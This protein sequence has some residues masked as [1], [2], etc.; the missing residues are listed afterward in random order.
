MNIKNDFDFSYINEVVN[1]RETMFRKNSIV[2][3]N[4]KYAFKLLNTFPTSRLK[5]DV[6]S[7]VLFN[8]I[9]LTDWLLNRIVVLADYEF[10]EFDDTTSI[11]SLNGNHLYQKDKPINKERNRKL[12]RLHYVMKILSVLYTTSYVAIPDKD[13]QDQQFINAFY[14][15][16]IRLECDDI[17]DSVIDEIIKRESESSKTKIIYDKYLEYRLVDHFIQG[18]YNP[19]ISDLYDDMLKVIHYNQFSINTYTSKM[20][21]V[22]NNDYIRYKSLSDIRR[23]INRELGGTNARETFDKLMDNFLI[24]N[25]DDFIINDLLKCLVQDSE[26]CRNEQYAETLFDNFRDKYQ[27][28][29]KVYHGSRDVSGRNRNIDYLVSRYKDGSISSSKDIKQAL[30]FAA[31][32]SYDYMSKSPIL[33]KGFVAELDITEDMKAL[34]VHKMLIDL[35]EK[36]PKLSGWI[37]EGFLNEQEVLIPAEYIKAARI[38]S[39]EDAEKLLKEMEEK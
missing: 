10:D 7:L 18:V 38:M 8:E 4:K 35:K 33:H 34:D 19:I 23:K 11:P 36:L 32:E 6:S 24:E 14:N 26:E 17:L 28:I 37:S 20:Y 15:I 9:N 1:L 21:E 39:Y 12:F 25:Y 16:V 31:Y 22:Y 2:R 27:Y 5:N 13:E 3:L 29:G 30:K